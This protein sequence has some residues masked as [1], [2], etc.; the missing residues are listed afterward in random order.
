MVDHIEAETLSEKAYQA[1]KDSILHNEMQPDEVLSITA[2]ARELGI[3]QTPVRE[4]ISRLSADGLVSYEAHK[5]VRVATLTEENVRQVYEVRMLLEPYAARLAA[6]SIAGNPRLMKDLQSLKARAEAICRKRLDL[7]PYDEYLQIDLRLNEML[8]MAGGNLLLSEV[9]MF[10]GYRSLRIRTFAEAGYKNRPDPRIHTITR[11]HLAIM[12]AILDEKPHEAENRVRR[13]LRNAEVR[14]I[15]AIE[16]R[17]RSQHG[18]AES[19]P[20]DI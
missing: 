15:Q 10:V 2:L 11:E 14:T 7:V 17:L 18:D 1:I 3:S 19:V 16:D 13:H 5:R 9:L 12:E 8:M 4:A 20:A 6:G